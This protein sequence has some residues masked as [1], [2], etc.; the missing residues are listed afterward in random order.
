MDYNYQ[1]SSQRFEPMHTCL[2]CGEY[3]DPVDCPYFLNHYFYNRAQGNRPNFPWNYNNHAIE[4][5]YFAPQERSRLKEAIEHFNRT[6]EQIMASDFSL[7]SNPE[8][9][10]EE[11]EEA[12]ILE[13]Q[14]EIVKETE[15]HEG[16]KLR[17]KEEPEWYRI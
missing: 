6:Y 16:D 10:P 12:I 9:D 8:R 11:Q 14:Q 2:W 7:P 17:T 3:H 15:A 4:P 13:Q 1:C 5:Q